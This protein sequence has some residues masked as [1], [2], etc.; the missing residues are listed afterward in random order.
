[1]VTGESTLFSILQATSRSLAA[2]GMTHQTGFS[3]WL[4]LAEGPSDAAAVCQNGRENRGAAPSVGIAQAAAAMKS[5]TI[6]PRNGKGS[7]KTGSGS[8]GDGFSGAIEG[9]LAA[10]G[11]VWRDKLTRLHPSGCIFS[12]ARRPKN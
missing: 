7:E 4:F 2:L 6:S 9:L 8:P 10:G 11:I 5:I 1:M 12:G 3:T